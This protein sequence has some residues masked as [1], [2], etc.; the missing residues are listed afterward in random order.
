MCIR[1]A[2]IGGE[3]QI[4]NACNAYYDLCTQIPT[5]LMHELVRPLVRDIIEKGAT[6]GFGASAIAENPASFWVSLSRQPVILKQR[7]RLNSYPIFDRNDYTRQSRFR[8]LDHWLL[9]GHAKAGLRVSPLLKLAVAQ[10]DKA[11]HRQCRFNRRLERGEIAMANNHLVAH[12]RNAF[13]DPSDDPNYR[14]R[15]LVRCW[16]KVNV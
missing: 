9:S 11:L 5:F 14:G 1:P 10:L 16:M 2:K 12:R 15:L 13:S 8:Y 7:L 6:A 3:F 4:A